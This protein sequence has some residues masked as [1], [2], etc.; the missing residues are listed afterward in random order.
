M[1]VITLITKLNN[2][3]VDRTAKSMGEDAC[4]CFFVLKINCIFE[5]TFV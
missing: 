3:L 4:V 1:T 5:Y 2:Y